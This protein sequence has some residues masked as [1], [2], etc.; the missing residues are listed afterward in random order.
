MGMSTVVECRHCK[1]RKEF[2]FG[3][4]FLNFCE[5]QL[6]DLSSPE[7]LLM[8]CPQKD[9]LKVK[10]LIASKKVHLVKGFGYQVF[11]CNRCGSYGNEFVYNLVD[12]QGKIVYRGNQTCRKCGSQ[13]LALNISCEE[14]AC[15][16]CGQIVEQT[17]F[18]K[19]D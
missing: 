4:G 19:W 2:L 7:S 12:E 9:K 16:I 13:D 14:M 17:E 10:Q 5:E 15:P 3:V 1:I 8:Y 18:A 11:R 6:F